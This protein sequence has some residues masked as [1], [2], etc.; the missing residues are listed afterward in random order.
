MASPE[1]D[2]KR[3]E[4]TCRKIVNEGD[5]DKLTARSIRRTA[6]ERM[7][8]EEQRLDQV[9]YKQ[10]VKDIVAKALEDLNNSKSDEESVPE[11]AAESE[12][13]SEEK[14]EDETQAHVQE[15]SDSDAGE[16]ESADGKESDVGG[17]D[18]EGSKKRKDRERNGKSDSEEEDFSDVNDSE[19]AKTKA[20][21][22]PKKRAS[23]AALPAKA[24]RTKTTPVSTPISK[25]NEATISNLKTYV[26][27]CGMRKV[28]SKELNGMNAAQQIRH[29]KKLLDD[30][31]MDG[32]PTLE[33]CK[34]IKAKR[35]LQAELEAIEGDAI[36]DD[37]GQLSSEPSRRR[38]STTTKRASYRL[39]IS[40]EEEDESSEE[41]DKSSEESDVGDEGKGKGK[42]G[43]EN[44]DGDGD[45]D[46]SDKNASDNEE[47]ANEE[48]EES[49]ESD[50]YTE[51]DGESDGGDRENDE[52]A[53]SA[54][55]ADMASSAEDSE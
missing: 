15:D 24:K 44:G 40:S 46:G 43:D 22:K 6:E 12:E 25:S 7:G 33:K 13:K 30:L 20:I 48:S 49:E 8:L 10:M 16:H 14:S 1:L 27:K 39:D 51:S 42:D 41:D 31:G 52:A 5:L 26:N 11:S 28:W 9:P 54:D 19:P 53:H 50:A 4:K 18:E 36:I 3:L 21:T 35:D 47:Q 45:G 34:K 2:I 29:L 32:R 37:V 23:E 55:E 38:R 17:N